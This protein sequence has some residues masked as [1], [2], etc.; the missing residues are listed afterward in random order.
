M[1]VV[2]LKVS[3][4]IVRM[5]LEWLKAVCVFVVHFTEQCVC[6][7]VCVCGSGC[8]CVNVVC[9]GCVLV[10]RVHMSIDVGVCLCVV[11][12]ACG[13]SRNM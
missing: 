12:C 1:C 11:V 6:V 4:H 5:R 9:G 13:I 3:V 10:W 7:C 8:Q 2:L